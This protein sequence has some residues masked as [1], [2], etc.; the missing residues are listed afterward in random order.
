MDGFWRGASIAHLT[1]ERGNDQT[2]LRDALSEGGDIRRELA[3]RSESRRAI[4]LAGVTNGD[5]RF[6]EGAFESDETRGLGVSGPFGGGR[7][8]REEPT[9]PRMVED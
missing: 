5:Q 9:H 8:I 1:D 7:L 2:I 3:Q 6:G 4:R